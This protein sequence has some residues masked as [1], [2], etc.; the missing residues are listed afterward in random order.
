MIKTV[1]NDLISFVFPNLCII[2][3]NE[4]PENRKLLCESHFKEFKPVPEKAIR[5]QIARIDTCYFS[6]LSILY[7]YDQNLKTIIHQLKYNHGITLATYFAE[8]FLELLTGK[9]FDLVTGVPL[10]TARERDR[11][12][13]QSYLL[14]QAVSEIMGIPFKKILMRNANTKSQTK[15]T[16]E[17]R[18]KNVANAFACITSV[19]NLHIL[20]IDDLIT[21]GST[22]NECASVLIKNGARKVHAA[23]VATP[24]LPEEYELEEEEFTFLDRL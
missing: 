13:N 5:D 4:L 2:C 9:N 7:Q 19:A 16:R 3:G 22:I 23:A 18:R 14:A 12:Y 6:D 8:P 20:L 24:V 11:G 21:T 1:I 17:Q 15:L 10:N